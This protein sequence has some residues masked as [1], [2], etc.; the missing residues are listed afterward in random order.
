[1]NR[2]VRKSA[3]DAGTGVGQIDHLVP[4]L[5]TPVIE[6]PGRRIKG[7]TSVQ[8]NLPRAL[9]SV[10]HSP[11]PPLGHLYPCEHRCHYEKHKASAVGKKRPDRVDDRL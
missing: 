10:I 6:L 3:H 5:P 7:R 2:D 11:I 8:I 9:G 1:M 4:G